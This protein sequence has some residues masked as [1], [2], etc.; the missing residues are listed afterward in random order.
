M[1]SLFILGSPFSVFHFLCGPIRWEVLSVFLLGFIRGSL[2]RNRRGL[3]TLLGAAVVAG[4]LLTEAW[5]WYHLRAA[6]ADLLAYHPHDARTHLAQCLALW[7]SHAE[8]HL[9]AGRAARQSGDFEAA[10]RELRTCQRLL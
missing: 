2:S 9:L 5:A 8:A 6:R 7:P 4:F 10:D 1:R 3:F